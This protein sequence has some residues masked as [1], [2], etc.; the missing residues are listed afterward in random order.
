MKGNTVEM[1]FILDRSASMG[2]LEQETIDG[3]NEMIGKQRRIEGHALVSTVLF[4]HR[5]EVI[6]DRIDL[7]DV[8]K[9][10]EKDYYVR[11]T[12]ALLDAIGRSMI[13]IDRLHEKRGSER[14]KTIFIV[15]T[16]GLENA[17]KEFGHADIKRL[18]ERQ[19]SHYGWE[20]IFLGANIDAIHTAQRFG[21]GPDRAANY[22]SD[23]AGTRLNYEVISDVLDTF[24]G[25]RTVSAAWKSRID[26]DYDKRK[27]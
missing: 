16:D 15:T 14:P 11:G 20:F 18:I 12:T 1:V 3:F 6:H 2:G 7:D 23:H 22:H 17:S 24:R 9:M 13:R 4:D 10:T 5:F 26:E 25:N 8:P 27:K 21:I 19:K